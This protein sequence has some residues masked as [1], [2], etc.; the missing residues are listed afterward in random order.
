M[1]QFIGFFGEIALYLLGQVN[2][3]ISDK[4]KLEYPTLHAYAHKRC[5]IETDLIKNGINWHSFFETC[6][7]MR[8]PTK[9]DKDFIKTLSNQDLLDMLIIMNLALRGYVDSYEEK[10]EN[11]QI[12]HEFYLLLKEEIALRPNLSFMPLGDGFVDY[13]ESREDRKKLRDK[14]QNARKKGNLCIFCEGSNLR[15]NGNNW[16]CLDCGKYFRKKQ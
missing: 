14:K 10:S 13:L 15:S 2:A 8:K 6:E 4:M 7:F 11:C 9:E 5:E 16:Q 3:K 12:L 1:W